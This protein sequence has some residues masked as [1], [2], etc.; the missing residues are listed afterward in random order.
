MKKS[1]VLIIAV[2]VIVMIALFAA[3]VYVALTVN[4]GNAGFHGGF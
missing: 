3:I 1:D 2:G 4:N